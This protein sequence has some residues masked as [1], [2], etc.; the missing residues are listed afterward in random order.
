VT[1][2]DE[3]PNVAI[4]IKGHDVHP[5][6]VRQSTLDEGHGPIMPE[7]DHDMTFGI[8]HAD[9][10]TDGLIRRYGEIIGTRED[11]EVL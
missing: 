7:P 6:W 4:R 3:D 11:I 9:M 2:K 1:S 8:S 10:S 5:L